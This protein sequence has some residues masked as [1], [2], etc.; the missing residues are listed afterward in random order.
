VRKDKF[1]SAL[2]ECGTVVFGQ[3]IAI[4]CQISGEINKKYALSTHTIGQNAF[5]GKSI[6]GANPGFL[7]P[8]FILTL[9]YF[10]YV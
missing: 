5:I 7:A 8:D 6:R 2:E 4:M 1:Y 10:R 9:I 3:Y